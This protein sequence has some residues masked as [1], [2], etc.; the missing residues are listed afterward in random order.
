MRTTALA[1]AVMAG[2]AC[3]GQKTTQA[4]APTGTGGPSQSAG[5]SKAGLGAVSAPNAD[6]FPSTY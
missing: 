1:L 6:P 2:A 5:G 3:A 4:P